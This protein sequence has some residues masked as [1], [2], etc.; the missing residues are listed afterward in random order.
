MTLLLFWQEIKKGEINETIALALV[1]MLLIAGLSL[2]AP[3]DQI[4]TGEITDSACATMGSHAGMRKP[5]KDCALA[6]VQRGSKFVLFNATAKTI[7]QLDDQ[8]KPAQFAGAT[9]VVTGTLDASTKIIHVTGIK[10]VS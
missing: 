9:V 5:A 8:K 4:Y 2:A 6:C 3:K 7:Y 1:G 10:S